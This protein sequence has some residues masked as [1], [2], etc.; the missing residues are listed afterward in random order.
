MKTK[1]SLCTRLYDNCSPAFNTVSSCQ[2]ARHKTMTFY[3][4][5]TSIAMSPAGNSLTTRVCVFAPRIKEALY[6]F[7]VPL[8]TCIFLV[9]VYYIRMTSQRERE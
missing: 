4:G 2:R 3:S 8:Y 7:I 1:E 6:L 9:R 5:Y